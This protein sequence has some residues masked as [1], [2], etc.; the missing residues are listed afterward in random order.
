MLGYDDKYV[1]NCCE[2]LRLGVITNMLWLYRA[3]EISRVGCGQGKAGPLGGTRAI[4][5]V[6]ALNDTVCSGDTVL[7]IRNHNTLVIK[8]GH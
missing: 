4:C 3:G 1:V 2:Y 6:M 8:T 5:F 7:H